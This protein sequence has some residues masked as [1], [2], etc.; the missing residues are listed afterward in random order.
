MILTTPGELAAHVW[1]R[2][3]IW[4]RP[5]RR[6]RR[7]NVALATISVFAVV[8][9]TTTQAIGFERASLCAPIDLIAV[10]WWFI[11]LT[12]DPLLFFKD[13]GNPIA[14]L[15]AAGLSYYLAAPLCLAPLHIG[16]L[17]LP[18]PLVGREEVIVAALVMQVGLILLQLLLMA[19]AE[20]ALLWQ[21]V[22]LPRAGAFAIALGN[23]LIRAFR[24]AVYVVLIPA[25]MATMVKP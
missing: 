15:R 10:L 18:V 19:L 20:S 5:A 9:W 22:E 14:C 2:D 4:L 7:I 1:K 17:A 3:M 25:V 13:K 12:N 11:S 16:L 24:G 8:L 6:F 21:L 23:G